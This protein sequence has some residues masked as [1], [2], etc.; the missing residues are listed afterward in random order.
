MRIAALC[1]IQ[2]GYTA[3]RRLQPV[4]QGGALAIQLRD[5]AADGE[6][7]SD[8]LI[9][10]ELGELPD[11]YFA[12]GGDVVFRS[13]GDR[14]T[15]SA[16]DGCLA[17]PVLAIFPLIVLRPNPDIVTP[18]YLAW[19]INRPDAQRYFERMG[20][21]TGIR[22]IPRS[23]LS[24]L[25]LDI[26]D[27]ETQQRIVAADALSKREKALTILLAEKR[28]KIT[29]RILGERVKC[30]SRATEQKRTKR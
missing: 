29:S 6:V 8:T 16:L 3:R 9:R 11:R 19:A 22:M 7:N 12:R 14:N 23:V 1:T 13:R 17:E 24:D 5:V 25:R 10:V 2:A 20:R 4:L 18:E 26:P 27:V 30:S 15:A 28:R 21:G